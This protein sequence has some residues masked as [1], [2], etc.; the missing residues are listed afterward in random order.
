[1]EREALEA[2]GIREEQLLVPVQVVSAQEMTQLME[3]Q[4]VI[5]GF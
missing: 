1:V 5:V 3:Q 2:R 4:D